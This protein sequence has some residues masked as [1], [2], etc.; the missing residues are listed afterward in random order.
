MFFIWNKIYKDSERVKSME[1]W[2]I[3]QENIIQKKA[4]VI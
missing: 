4:L 1:K 3:Q 2:K